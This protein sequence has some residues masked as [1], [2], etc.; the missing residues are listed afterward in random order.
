MTSTDE[1]NNILLFADKTSNKNFPVVGD[2]ALD[3]PHL[4]NSKGTS[5][6]EGVP[7]DSQ[8]TN[9]EC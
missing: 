6:A 3:P 5:A 4:V 1:T 8:V 9:S 2:Q 7:P